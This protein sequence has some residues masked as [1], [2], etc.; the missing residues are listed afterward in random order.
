MEAVF[1]GPL[2]V[3]V[4]RQLQAL[5]FDCVL[6]AHLLDLPA[7]TVDAHVPVAVGSHEQAVER[8]LDTR[9]ADD[10]AGLQVGE[11][12]TLELT[13][14]HFADVAE[15]VGGEFVARVLSGRHLLHDDAGQLEL[16]HGH[17][18]DLRERRVFDDHDGPEARLAPP[19]PQRLAK[20]RFVLAG[21]AREQPDRFVEVLDLLGHDRDVER[22]AVLDEHAAVTIEQHA[23]R[24]AERNGPQMVVLG[25]LAVLLVVGH[26]REPEADP[27]RD[28]H[29]GDDVLNRRQPE[30]RIPP[31]VRNQ[32]RAHS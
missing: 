27:E 5:P 30:A 24:R 1:G 28:E 23:A 8:L 10:R 17:G 2:Q 29:H 11:L 32:E 14:G 21:D 18:G 4:D 13:L 20:A 9:L 3:G 19:A 6:L 12:G 7:E 31:I 15:Q 22:V 16:A 26:L 25:H